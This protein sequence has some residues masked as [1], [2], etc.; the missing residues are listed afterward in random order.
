MKILITFDNETDRMMFVNEELG[1]WRECFTSVDL[2][3]G[4]TIPNQRIAWLIIK[5]VPIHLWQAEVFNCIAGEIGEVIME[6]SADNLD[7]NLYFDIVG[8][9]VNGM[10]PINEKIKVKWFE[11][12]FEVW[13]TEIKESW[14]PDFLKQNGQ[15]SGRNQETNQSPEKSPEKMMVDEQAVES[16]PQVTE[17]AARGA[18]N[19]ET[20]KK[21]MNTTPENEVIND[22]AAIPVGINEEE[23]F[24]VPNSKG[25]E[26][27]NTP[28][29]LVQE[30]RAQE[31]NDGEAQLFS[32]TEPSFNMGFGLDASAMKKRKRGPTLST[33]KGKLRSNTLIRKNKV[34]DLNAELSDESKF[35][36]RKKIMRTKLR[37]KGK[38]RVNKIRL[39]DEVFADEGPS[40][41][42][43]YGT[44]WEEDSI[45]DE[46]KLQDD[47]KEP[48]DVDVSLSFEEIEVEVAETS[49][50]G[51]K[52]GI[53]WGGK[54]DLI[55]KTVEEEQ[56]EV[57]DK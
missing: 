37:R 11:Q 35:N 51:S 13:I 41:E 55:R 53:D 44:E 29:P 9:V 56:V 28:H 14:T 12:E 52:V 43:G 39:E 3:D 21:G 40:L 16:E 48:V 1:G 24:D 57:L 34:P 47:D 54:H 31:K 2:W 17:P 49:N 23:I 19:E 32:H 30:S 45:T 10:G 18:D 27:V 15:I 38:I 36:P 25:C 22:V 7:L 6:S 42:D 46:S 50:M 26:R 4:Q 20:T 33:R 8:V 5:G